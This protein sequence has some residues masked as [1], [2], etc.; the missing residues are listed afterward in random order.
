MSQLQELYQQVILDH[1]KRPRNFRHM[2]PPA[3]HAEGFNPL[4]GD[5]VTVFIN[6]Q[7]DIVDDVSFIGAG[8]AICMASASMM[9]QLLKGKTVAQ[10][11]QMFGQFR[12]LVMGDVDMPAAGD[13]LDKLAVF[14]GVRRFPMR[15]KCAVL[16]WHTIKAALDGRDEAVSTE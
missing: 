2:P 15:V 7:A 14:A 10:V 6:V 4:C 1:S 5:R 8:C 12:E 3:R 9:T 11:E 13:E 16:P